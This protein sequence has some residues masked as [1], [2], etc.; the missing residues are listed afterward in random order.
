MAGETSHAAHLFA[1]YF[2]QD[3]LLDDP[4]WGSVVLRFRQSE[5]FEVAR[6]A[7]AELEELLARSTEQDLQAFLFGPETLCFYDPRPEGFTLTTWLQEIVHVLSG[8][9]PHGPIEGSDLQARREV[10]LIARRALL[11]E[12]DPIVAARR[13][14]ALRGSV[15]VT[16]HDPDFTTFVV[17]DSETDSLPVVTERDQWS[18]EALTRLEPEIAQARDWALSIGKPAFE[19]VVRRFGTAG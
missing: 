8:G 13:L 7:Q 4:D 11:G 14:G 6:N 10:V 15:G 19:N 17:I 16:D 12:L 1:A 5:P 3:C 9:S 18:P 2:H